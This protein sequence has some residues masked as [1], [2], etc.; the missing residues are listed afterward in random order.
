MKEEH[1]EMLAKGEHQVVS[2]SLLQFI[3]VVSCM[4]KGKKVKDSRHIRMRSFLSH[5][6]YYCDNACAICQCWRGRSKE[7]CN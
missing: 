7:C 4:D 2:T 5:I 3:E 1:E 6:L